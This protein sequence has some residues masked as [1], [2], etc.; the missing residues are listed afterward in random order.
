MPISPFTN[1]VMKALP[2]A[3]RPNPHSIDEEVM[4]AVANGWDTDELAKASYINDKQPNPAFVVTNI[5]RLCEYSPKR[6]TKRTGW[7]YGHIDCEVHPNC[8]ICRCHPGEVLHH[9]SVAP[10]KE[11]KQ[12]IRAAISRMRLPR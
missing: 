9:V 12:M 5:R 7:E 10:T 4:K 1:D 6:E 2:A 8:Q 11:H 3:L